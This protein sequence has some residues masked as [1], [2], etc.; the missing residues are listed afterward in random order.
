MCEIVEVAARQL[1]D[2]NMIEGSK[3]SRLSDNIP[4]ET[5]DEPP[6]PFIG[7]T[8]S[9]NREG[10]VNTTVL[11][12]TDLLSP[13]IRVVP[14]ETH[15][16]QMLRVP[17]ESDESSSFLWDFTEDGSCQPPN[18]SHT[19]LENIPLTEP[20]PCNPECTSGFT[21][22]NTVSDRRKMLQETAISPSIM[23]PS[24]GGNSDATCCSQGNK[25]T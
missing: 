8:L 13:L 3:C 5:N 6:S 9:G 22:E 24:I 17:C 12:C 7:A 15:S 2:Q 19:E 16:E 14:P 4:E 18:S 20:Q 11:N 23:E 25:V 1:Q 10:D 21:P